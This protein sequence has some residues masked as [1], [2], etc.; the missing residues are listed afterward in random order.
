MKEKN[1]S[2]DHIGIATK[3]L[4][5]SDIFWKMLGFVQE[6]DDELV[7]EQGVKVRYLSS[8]NSDLNH[9]RIELLEPTG[10]ETPIGR[11]LSKKGPGVQQICIRVENLKETLEILLNSGIELID[12]TPKKGAGGALIAFIHP[13]STGGVLVE[14]SQH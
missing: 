2:V 4:D 11:F 8:P 10:D 3:S 14:L 12:K 7:E 9:T 13:K 6:M 1:I 5:E